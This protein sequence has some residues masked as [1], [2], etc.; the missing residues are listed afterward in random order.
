MKYSFNIK[1]ANPVMAQKYEINASHKDLSAI[2]GEIRY[3]NSIKALDLLD[4]VIA[5]EIP[6]E[7]K[8]HNKGM[9]LRH[10]LHGRK[11]A[12]P[13]R[14]AKQ[15]RLTLINAI[16]NANNKGMSGEEMY[17]V[18]ATANKTHIERRYPSKGSLAWGRGRYG[19]S[20]ILHSDLEY[21]KIE[22]GLANKDEQWLTRNM[23]YFIK[24]K[25]HKQK[26]TVQKEMPKNKSKATSKPAAKEGVAETKVQA[27]A[28]V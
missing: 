2:C 24:A 27:K 14:A 7:Y 22:I 16:A 26:A 8:R 5:K 28:K 15:V 21:A 19:R 18:H 6:I 10:E 9:G 4:R 13:V 17:I 11:G 12:Y 25:D 23:K 1:G 20:A 3:M